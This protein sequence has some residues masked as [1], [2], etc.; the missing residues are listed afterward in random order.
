[1]PCTQHAQQVYLGAPFL[2]GLNTYADH[3]PHHILKWELGGGRLG[4]GKGA[5]G[6]LEAPPAHALF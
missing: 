6:S 5:C 3:H 1:M 4:K 2:P